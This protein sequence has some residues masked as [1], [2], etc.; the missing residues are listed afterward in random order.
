MNQKILVSAK[1]YNN[2]G[3]ISSKEESL[4]NSPTRRNTDI[5]ADLSPIPKYSF[6]YSF[7]G[8][9]SMAEKLEKQL[10]KSKSDVLKILKAIYRKQ[11]VAEALG[12]FL[13]ILTD[14][15]KKSSFESL[16]K[17]SLYIKKHIRTTPKSIIPKLNIE[18]A[19]SKSATKSRTGSDYN[20]YLLTQSYRNR[21]YNGQCKTTR[22]INQNDRDSDSLDY[23]AS[24]SSDEDSSDLE[25]A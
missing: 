19:L 4:Y 20:E 2:S 8:C 11:L 23:P 21:G 13:A 1:N 5:S 15:N 12:N 7:D 6:D 16:L 3:I 18:K 10:A 22:F 25:Y 17:F 9:F 14:K 24:M